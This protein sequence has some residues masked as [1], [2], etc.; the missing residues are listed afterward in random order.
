[1]D[2]HADTIGVQVRRVEIPEAI[3]KYVGRAIGE[4]PLKFLRHESYRSPL[5][6]LTLFDQPLVHLSRVVI[7]HLGIRQLA[8]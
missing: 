1:M 4:L 7:C 3:A 6:G 8:R 2:I 5:L